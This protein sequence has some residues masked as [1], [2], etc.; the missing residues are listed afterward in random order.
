[1]FRDA[2]TKV[3]GRADLSEAEAAAAMDAIVEGRASPAEVAGLLVA[4]R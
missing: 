1:M 3:M 4:W 2:L